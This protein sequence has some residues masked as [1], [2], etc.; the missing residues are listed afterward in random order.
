MKV[1]VTGSSGFLGQY[2][3]AELLRQGHEVIA[4]GRSLEKLRT[5]PWGEH[6]AV[7]FLE[8]DLIDKYLLIAALRDVDAVIHLAAAKA[9]TFDIQYRDTVE[10]TKILIE[11]MISTQ[12]LRLVAVSSFSVFDYLH[13]PERDLVN[14][15]SRLETNPENRD[16]YAQTKLI[17]EK[18]CQSFSQSGGGQVTILRPGIVYGRNNFWNARLGIQLRGNFWI[19]IGTDAQLPLTYVENCA[20]AIVVALTTQES[21]GK[22]INIVD[23]ELPTQELYIKKL[24]SKSKLKPYIFSIKWNLMCII[25]EI[26]F[27]I[28]QAFFQGH[29]KV[30]SFLVPAN[31][32]ARFKP[33]KYS[34]SYAQKILSWQPKYSLDMALDR[35]LS[36]LNLL[37]IADLSTTTFPL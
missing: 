29:L 3:V 22:T 10:I 27:K 25:S 2:V 33:L 18:L 14:E 28:S 9:G 12:V 32:H 34:N 1:L 6:P 8:L 5:L 23:S 26:I 7:K 31:F 20:S 24:I 21:I 11:A 13:I 15:E 35:S 16:N 37:E 19:G 30:P 36:N 17:Q 4:V